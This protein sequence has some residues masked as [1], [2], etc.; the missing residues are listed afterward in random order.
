MSDS[1]QSITQHLDRFW[2]VRSTLL[3]G[4]EI[5]KSVYEQ[6]VAWL[7]AL[8][9]GEKLL[10]ELAKEKDRA[11]LKDQR[12]NGALQVYKEKAKYVN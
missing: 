3:E 8:L 9:L 2:G 6:T 12:L 1:V 10:M 11:E 5:Y 7:N 4:Q